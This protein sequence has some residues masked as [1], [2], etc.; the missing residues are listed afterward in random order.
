[1][2]NEAIQPRPPFRWV[3]L[4]ELATL[5]FPNANRTLTEMLL[6]SPKGATLSEESRD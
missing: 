6:R 2:I 3:T 1:M 5:K 4:D